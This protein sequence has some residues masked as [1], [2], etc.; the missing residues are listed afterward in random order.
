MLDMGLN[1][2]SY[3]NSEEILDV[4]ISFSVRQNRLKIDFKR[5][6]FSPFLDNLALFVTETDLRGLRAR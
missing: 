5:P 1:K 3:T 2:P 6:G 4:L